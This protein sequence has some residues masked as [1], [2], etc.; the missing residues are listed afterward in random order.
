M[1][2]PILA[3]TTILQRDQLVYWKSGILRQAETLECLLS[4]PFLCS[5]ETETQ[6]DKHPQGQVDQ[7]LWTAAQSGPYLG[8]ILPHCNSLPSPYLA[9]YG[10]V[11]SDLSSDCIF[12]NFL[13]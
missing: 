8:A 11:H 7:L 2:R 6:L 5:K 9:T 13:S 12:S 1:D 10:L 3:I 4:I